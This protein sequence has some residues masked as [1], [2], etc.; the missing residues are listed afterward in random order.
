M[1][2]AAGERIEAEV[3]GFSA[4][5]CT[6]CRLVISVAG[7]GCSAWPTG[8]VS[9]AVV[10]DELLGSNYYRR[11]RQTAG[12]R[13]HSCT[14]TALAIERRL[15]QPLA[16][17]TDPRKPLDVGIRAINCAAQRRART[18]RPVC[19]LRRRQV[20]AARMMTRYTDAD[21]VVV[22]LIGERP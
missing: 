4:K 21:V 5:A 11:Q 6:R 19:R 16:R 22:G 18:A 13:V 3:V 2:N 9:E 8:S 15:Y 7:A 12:R 14:Q 1:I 10:G 17:A 20:R